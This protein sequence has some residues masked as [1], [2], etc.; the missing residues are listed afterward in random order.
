MASRKCSTPFGITEVRG[1]TRGRKQ[2]ARQ[3]CS[4]PFGITEVRGRPVPSPLR[5]VAEVLNAFRHH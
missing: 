5:A 3:M 2:H 1:M 4:T